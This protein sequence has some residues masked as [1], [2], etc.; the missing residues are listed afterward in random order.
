[1]FF[2][3]FFLKAF[4]TGAPCGLGSSAGHGAADAAGAARLG[5]GPRGR[6]RRAAA[7]AGGGTFEERSGD[8]EMEMNGW[9]EV[10]MMWA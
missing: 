7:A 5:S 9:M 2:V 10:E 3:P 6:R 1:M 4:A 8:S